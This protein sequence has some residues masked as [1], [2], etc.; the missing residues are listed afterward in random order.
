MDDYLN[1]DVT[2]VIESPSDEKIN[3][4]KTTSNGI[5]NRDE[6]NNSLQ[7]V[8]IIKIPTD[9]TNISRTT[10][11][12]RA[13]SPTKS[14]PR[15]FT[16]RNINFEINDSLLGGVKTI[17]RR[18]NTYMIRD[19]FM[20]EDSVEED[21]IAETDVIEQMIDDLYN[22]T[23]HMS[24]MANN[25]AT[26]FK[27]IYVIS[28]LFVVIAGAVIGVLSTEDDMSD[29]AKI[30]V[31]V[32]GFIITGIGTCMTT[33]SIEKRGVLLKDVSNKL[34]KISRQIKTLQYSE[35]KPKDKRLKLEEF[36]ADVDD[37]DMSIYD[38]NIITSPITKQSNFP[39]VKQKEYPSSR[40]TTPR[41]LKF[42][43]SDISPD[44]ET[45]TPRRTHSV[46]RKMRKRSKDTT[47]D[48][49][50]TSMRNSDL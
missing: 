23:M 39:P 5:K 9:D 14:T 28:T 3:I 24:S 2:I 20:S 4:K 34:R 31:S 22:E 30:V 11:Q 26:F 21:E 42:S 12:G 36:Y 16:D 17:Q 38:N 19:L 46:L 25:K 41:D 45:H 8:P 40:D 32:F 44:N 10:S 1:N 27:Y 33:F 35:L 43:D 47:N 7:K 49:A 13:K 6:L 18:G 50:A 48:S 29:A 37:M 15:L